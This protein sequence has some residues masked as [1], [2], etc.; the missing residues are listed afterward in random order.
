VPE[1]RRR[2]SYERE[3][4]LVAESATEARLWSGAKRLWLAGAK[5]SSWIR[6][7]AA[8]ESSWRSSFSRKRG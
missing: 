7:V 4:F 8:L 3:W 5:P 1:A 2:L 6:R